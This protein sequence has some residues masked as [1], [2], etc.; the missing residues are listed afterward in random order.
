MLGFKS[1]RPV[2]TALAGIEL[3]HMIRKGELRMTG[4][5]HPALQFY[6]LD[7]ITPAIVQGSARPSR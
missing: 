4:D 2:A 7:G 6:A 1:F 5:A 3:M